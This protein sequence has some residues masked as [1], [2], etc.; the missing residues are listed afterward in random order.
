MVERYRHRQIPQSNSSVKLTGQPYS[1]LRSPNLC[2]AE[3]KPHLD[4][5]SQAC[6]TWGCLPL[7]MR[8]ACRPVRYRKRQGVLIMEHTRHA[9]ITLARS[10]WGHKHQKAYLQIGKCSWDWLN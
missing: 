9:G 5:L 4:H 7:Q 2:Q 10:Y 1:S 6:E 8:P 3:C